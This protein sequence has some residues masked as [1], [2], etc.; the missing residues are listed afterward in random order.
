MDG[1]LRGAFRL[2]R[3]SFS[4]LTEYGFT[5]DGGGYVLTLP[6]VGGQLGLTVRVTDGG[7]VSTRV[8][9][10]D[11]G[12][13]YTLHLVE[14]SAGSFVGAVRGE[15]AAALA[16]IAD[17]CF[18]PS[19]FSGAGTA[20]AAEYMRGKY[21]SELEFL[22]ADTPDCAI[23]RR[24]DSKKWYAVF[25]VVKRGKLK[26]CAGDPEAEVEIINLRL[27]PEE[28]PE[29]VDGENFFPAYHM[30]KKNWVSVRAD[31]VP[32]RLLLRMIDVSYALTPAK[33]R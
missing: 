30:N 17:R 1:I 3:A 16:D 7:E 22:W 25:M 11:T 10:A 21:G 20:L 31:G 33:R 12:D 2:K 24:G 8:F 14:D 32:E 19:V 18:V 29:L 5:R 23:C 13:E 15:Y 6:L 27:P 28:L 26:G 4:K 9:D